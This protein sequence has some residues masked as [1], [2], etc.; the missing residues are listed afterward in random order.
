MRAKCYLAEKETLS[1]GLLLTS[2]AG[3]VL[4]K[5]GRV[6]DQQFLE[7]KVLT[8]NKWYLASY[9]GSNKAGDENRT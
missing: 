3:T 7:V 6:N 5:V 1:N 8:R 9:P 4:H 2:V